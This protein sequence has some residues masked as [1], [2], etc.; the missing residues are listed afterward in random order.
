MSD[1]S[2]KAPSPAPIS[3]SPRAQPLPPVEW[4]PEVIL[5]EHIDLM[6]GPDGRPLYPRKPEVILAYA[7]A[8]RSR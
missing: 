8:K 7:N 5:P 1:A 6:V 4:A 3:R 2:Q